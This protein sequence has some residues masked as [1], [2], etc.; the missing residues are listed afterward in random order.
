VFGV[1]AKRMPSPTH[2]LDAIRMRPGMYFGEP[3]LTALSGFLIGYSVA[4]GVHGLPQD[5]AIA[6]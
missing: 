6:Q 2:L 4:L 5:T 3:S 1:K